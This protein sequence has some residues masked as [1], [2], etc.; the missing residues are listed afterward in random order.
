MAGERSYGAFFRLIEGL[1]GDRDELKAS[2]VGQFTR[3]RTESLREMT[4]G[5]YRTMLTALR[6]QQYSLAQLKKA[7]SKA[8]HQLQR[9]GIDTLKW[10]EVNAFCAQS[11]IAGKPFGWLSPTEL[12]ALT[13]KMRAINDK[14]ER[15]RQAAEAAEVEAY[16]EAVIR[17][18][19]KQQQGS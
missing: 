15:N 9:Y 8:L 11:R 7:R 18:S 2:L 4:D 6:R 13:R 5:E 14:T 12:D 19:I 10:D 16:N 3:G 1:E 17:A